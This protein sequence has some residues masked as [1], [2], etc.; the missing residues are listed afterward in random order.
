[1]AAAMVM[2]KAIKMRIVF[3]SFCRA[4]IPTTL[5]SRATFSCDEHQTN[6]C[7]CHAATASFEDSRYDGPGF[8]GSGN[9]GPIKN[10]DAFVEQHETAVAFFVPF[11]T[12]LATFLLIALACR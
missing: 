6:W 12:L 3:P 10:L 9:M 7:C 8:E 1:M 4:L 11:L 5:T 2:A